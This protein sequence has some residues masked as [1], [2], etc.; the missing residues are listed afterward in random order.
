MVGT[1]FFLRATDRAEREYIEQYVSREAAEA[2]KTLR[3]GEAIIHSS[4]ISGV[5]FFVRAPFSKVSEVTDEEIAQ[6]NKA[7]QSKSTT[8]GNDVIRD[9]YKPRLTDRETQALKV[10]KDHYEKNNAPILAA[11]LQAI[12][13]IQGGTRQRLLKQMMEKKLIK[14]VTLCGK[15]GRPSH[16]IVPLP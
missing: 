9:L 16:G 5:R 1:R 13:G 6:I 2:V 8:T 10:I 11:A 7:H 12:L 3:Q 4:T 15:R 14:K